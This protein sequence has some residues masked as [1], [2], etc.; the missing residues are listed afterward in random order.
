MEK[1]IYSLSTYIYC[2]SLK[3]LFQIKEKEKR[4]KPLIGGGRTGSLTSVWNS[5]APLV[6]KVSAKMEHHK[7]ALIVLARS[8][9]NLHGPN[10]L[11]IM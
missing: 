3:K 8:I 10:P 9:I 5:F 1:Y 6:S 11:N 2:K 4:R 7:H